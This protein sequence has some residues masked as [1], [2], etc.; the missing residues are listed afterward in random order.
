MFSSI[1]KKHITKKPRNSKLQEKYYI[2]EKTFVL[3][4]SSKINKRGGGVLISS[5]GVG[6][7]QKINKRPPPPSPPVY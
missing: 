3:H 7:N 5:A 4:H 6:K 2:N 1:T